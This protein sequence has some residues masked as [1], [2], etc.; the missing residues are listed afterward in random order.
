MRTNLGILVQGLHYYQIVDT[1]LATN[2][3]KLVAERKENNDDTP[4]VVKGES[5]N[6]LDVKRIT[7][8]LSADYIYQDDIAIVK[9]KDL[10]DPMPKEKQKV[11]LWYECSECNEQ[12]I[13]EN[14][15][16]C[17][18]CGKTVKWELETE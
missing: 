17:S 14:T 3:V 5:F 16:R 1:D 12:A 15:K 2:F 13:V 9:P 7:M 18:D 4:I 6:P 11:M 10:V 8:T